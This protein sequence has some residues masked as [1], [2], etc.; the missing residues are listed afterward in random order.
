MPN[1]FQYNY[2]ELKFRDK[3]YGTLPGDKDIFEGW[4]RSKFDDP[5]NTENTAKDLD[6]DK[7]IEEKTTTFRCD[8][9]G[10][11]VHAYQIKAMIAQCASLL[12][13]TINKRGSKQTLKEGTFIKGI[14]AQNEFSSD[15]VYLL[16]YRKEADG[17][18]TFT[19]TVSGPQ[20]S[21]S[22]ISHVHFCQEPTIQ[23]QMWML[24]NRMQASNRGKKLNFEDF[25]NIFELAQEV[26][27]GGNRNHEV[28][29]FDLIKFCP[30]DEYLE[31]K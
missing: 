20:G 17:T 6:L 11:Y 10:I 25:Q 2:A 30:W 18:D 28:G 9:V 24:Q 7:E 12:E 29:K 31:N 8:D 26:G 23:F 13:L 3:L 21:R 22:I 15:K 14:N 1:L 27:L 16:P 19:G 4:M 5:E